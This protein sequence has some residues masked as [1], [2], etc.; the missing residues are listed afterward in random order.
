M[1]I[2]KSFCHQCGDTLTGSEVNGATIKAL[3]SENEQLRAQLHC[4]LQASGAQDWD[5][6]RKY[7]VKAK[8]VDR[9]KVEE[10]E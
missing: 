2:V 4:A 5:A 6:V 8:R 10:E 7:L 1:K 3:R 9:V